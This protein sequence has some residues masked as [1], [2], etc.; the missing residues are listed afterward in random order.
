MVVALREA[1]RNK[2]AR[3]ERGEND[4]SFR[5]A[6]FW[7]D[8]VDQVDQLQ[9]SW[10]Q[11]GDTIIKRYRDERT[12]S[13]AEMRR[14]LNVLWANIKVLMPALYGKPPVPYVEREFLQQ[15]PTARLA[16]QI[17]EGTLKNEIK[18][19]GLHSSIRRAL[20]DYLLPGRGTVWVRYEPEFG[21][22]DSIPFEAQGSFEDE[23]EGIE[24]NDHD[25]KEKSLEN[26]GEQLVTE[27][28][29]VDYIYWKDLYI[30]PATARTW[31][32]VQAIGKRV[33]LSRQEAVERFGEEVGK[34]LKY[35]N[36]ASDQTR[37]VPY[38]DTA[39]FQ[40]QSHRNIEVFE[41]WN[42]LD[43][44][45]YWV[46]VGYSYL[47][48]VKDDPLGLVKF[49]PIPMPLSATLTNESMVPV[50]D[51]I[52]YQDQAMQIDELTQRLAMLT[53]AC[54][55][56]GC[57]DASNGAL[58][59]LLQEGFENDL[60]PVD[61]W[62]AFAEKGGV[63]GGIA[64]LPI[65]EIQKVIE[66]L[67]KVRQQLMMDLDMVTGISDIIRGTT[68]SRE[69]LG[70]IRLKNNNAGT[71]LSDRQNEV[72][73]FVVETLNIVGEICAKY[74]S[75]KKLIECSNILYN[76]ELQP[77]TILEEFE[78]PAEPQQNQASAPAPQGQQG[79]VPPGPQQGG[80]PQMGGV[81]PFQGGINSIGQPPPANNVIPFP[82][83]DPKAPPAVGSPMGA[84]PPQ[85]FFEEPPVDPIVIIAD[86]VDAA[87][88]LLRKD[89]PRMYRIAIE[90]DSTVFGDAAQERQDAA[91]FIG[92]VSKYL[93][94]AAQLGMQL[95]EAVPALAQT[96]LWGIRK[97]RVGRDVE[98]MYDDF[99]TK[100][101]KRVKHQMKNP[102]PSPEEQKAQADLEATKLETQAKQ[103]E[104]QI[105]HQHL[106]ETNQMEMQKMQAEHAQAQQ[107]AQMD[108]EMKQKEHQLKLQEM[109]MKF[110]LEMM[111]MEMQMKQMQMQGQLEQQSAELQNQ[112]QQT[113][114]AQTMEQNQQQHQQ[115]MEQ[116]QMQ[117]EQAREQHQQ[118][119]QQT[120]LKGEQAKEQHTQKMAQTKM[121]G[122]Q[123]EAKHKQTMQQAAVK[124]KAG[125][126]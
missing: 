52:E 83:L 8:Q 42:K 117:G 116:T 91:A 28:V 34:E 62:A 10:L 102:K 80:A 107:Q 14:R 46:S 3:I 88:K 31:D 85:P 78:P 11:R 86:R 66:T 21:Q 82:N 24:G 15:D 93:A 104:L 74:Y 5:L 94:G 35:T 65:E 44:K 55:I 119:M 63:Q 72:S 111:K 16:S 9:K 77:E 96:L 100:V 118:T 79:S 114:H 90:T 124:K 108:M 54:K 22:G 122:Q 6:K 27:Q 103:A 81:N 23:L 109:E 84:P 45:V 125:A 120:E 26:T 92:E 112:Q 76:E 41:I 29:P 64:L 115:S 99:V 126:K 4:E 7:L 12:R 38:S 89:V 33:H 58:K 57:Y 47:C 13:D 60:I 19:N 32:E 97:F 43:R 59:R 75:E 113:E 53:K 69:T 50:P 110:K 87:I 68:D 95:P 123:Q 56:A 106:R 37:K 1:P 71:R 61:A 73:S 70:G 48:D 25:P 121:A 98:A 39:I 18:V 101:T 36:T 2:K 20:L 51:Y 105:T 67:T 17:L 49:F 30:F 40:S